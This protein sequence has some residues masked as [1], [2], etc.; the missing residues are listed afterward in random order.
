[1]K[2]S[3]VDKRTQATKG[4]LNPQNYRKDQAA[5]SAEKLLELA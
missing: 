1:L 2:K 3:D 5:Q 4:K